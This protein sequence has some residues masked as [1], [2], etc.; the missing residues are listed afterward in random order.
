M[1]T[2]RD[3][4]LGLR[5]LSKKYKLG[6]IMA[7]NGRYDEPTKVRSHRAQEI[8][9]IPPS[10]VGTYSLDQV[11]EWFNNPS[12]YWSVKGKPVQNALRYARHRIALARFRRLHGKRTRNGLVDF[13][14]A[15]IAPAAALCLAAARGSGLWKGT[16]PDKKYGGWRTFAMQMVLWLAYK[17]G[18]GGIAASPFR[19]SKHQLKPPKG[20]AVDV[21]D[22][23]GLR[24]YLKQSGDK[25]LVPY[26][27]WGNDDGHGDGDEVHFSD[28]GG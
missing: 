14:G 11:V 19:P 3:L 22:H 8:L 7:I 15:W 21:S 17:A 25:R 28:D 20:Y 9:G 10:K 6:W 2:I 1:A 13:D 26:G 12:E 4:Q 18:T 23:E 5:S 16:I 24:A 27:G